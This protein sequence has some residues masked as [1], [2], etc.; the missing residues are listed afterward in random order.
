MSCS[1]LETP[2]ST[3]IPLHNISVSSSF[4]KVGDDINT[5]L[6]ALLNASKPETGTDIIDGI[7]LWECS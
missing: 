2:D 4:T 3:R 5:K 1:H 6:F 7:V